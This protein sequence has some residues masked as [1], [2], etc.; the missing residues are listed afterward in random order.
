MVGIN[1]ENER[2]VASANDFELR[3][4]AEIDR[5]MAATPAMLHSID[6]AGLI[7]SVS[8]AWLAKLG[9]SREE[10]L[11]R[12]STDFL[13]PESRE[14]AIIEVL[15]EFFR[16]GRIENAQYRMIKKCG[17]S[18]DVL[19]SGVLADDP[20]GHGR[21]SL[22]VVT[23]I[24]AL[25]ETK[26]R[27]AESE[28]RYRS[29]V[30]DQSDLV[31]LA[32]PEGE[33]RYVNEAYASQLGLRPEE[34]VGNSLFNFV[35]GG[36][37]AVVANELARLGAG[38]EKAECENRVVMPD[39]A[40]RWFA[41][42]NRALYDAEGRITLI[43]CVG[44]DIQARVDAEQR[45]QASEA[46]YRFLADNSTDLILLIGPDGRRLYAS[47]ACRK[48]LGYEPDETVALSLT[49]AIHP[50]DAP[51]V[52]PIIGA[53]PGDTLLVY[54]MRRK[55]GSY[56]WVET[57]GKTVELASGER[58]RLIIVRDIEKRVAAEELIRASEARYRLLADNSTDVVMALD[59]NLVRTYVSPASLEM[60]GH[61]PEE[62]IGSRTADSAHPEDAGPLLEVLHSMLDGRVEKYTGV[63][64][65]RHRDGRWIW[66]ETCYRAVKDAATGEV[67]GI[68]GSARDVSARKAVEDQLSAASARLEFLSN[69]DGLTGLANRR[70]FDEALAREYRRARR[71]GGAVALLMLDV[72]RF[73][74]FN[75]LYGHPAGDECLRRVAEAIAASVRRPGDVAARYGGEEFA[76]V[77]PD[78]D[79]MGA[80]A[81]ATNILRAVRDL[82]VEHGGSEL[83]IA[84]LSAGVAAVRPEPSDGSPDALLLEADRA[85]YLAKAGGRNT[86]MLGSL[87][88]AVVE[89]KP[90][91]A[92]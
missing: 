24:T 55:D 64:R 31:S 45:L 33:L 82:A 10:V 91:A 44:R 67:S 76:V 85:L 59:R 63:N 75:D 9:Y 65:R 27:L 29:L 15:P 41:W 7:V 81:V 58:Q 34:V 37:R 78:T 20:S 50:D 71:D 40:T 42:T 51:R 38:G 89:P 43:H 28:A 49:D 74:A 54:R 57:T 13:T 68:V 88:R 83:K 14:R 84:T 23:D 92:A 87:S 3:L 2:D 53:R 6:E 26:R 1:V 46:R 66:A 35:P 36:E 12:P 47:P 18:I 32:T 19:M 21:V 62:L 61:A 5:R 90:S 80:V 79:E 11:G 70:A 4:R 72:D 22:A 25:S 86:V 69:H 39:G 77:L 60:F 30:E 8:D 52:L 48:L 17:G 73:K 16:V 56:V